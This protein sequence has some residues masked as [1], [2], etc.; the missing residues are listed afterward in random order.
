MN[1]DCLRGHRAKFQFCDDFIV[2]QEIIDRVIKPFVVIG[3][4]KTK[5]IIP[6]PDKPIRFTTSEWKIER[7][8]DPYVFKLSRPMTDKEKYELLNAIQNGE[9]VLEE[10]K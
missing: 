10:I 6:Q 5:Y 7:D 1:S 4:E 9:M 8:S 3:D 2:P